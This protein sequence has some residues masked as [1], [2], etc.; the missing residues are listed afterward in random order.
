MKEKKILGMVQ[1][2]QKALSNMNC[3]LMSKHCQ[4]RNCP[5]GSAY[6]T[7]AVGIGV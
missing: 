2:K 4:E 5:L 6:K 7:A 3:I 1:Q